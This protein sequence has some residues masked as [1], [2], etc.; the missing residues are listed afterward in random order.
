[1]VLSGVAPKPW[2]AVDAEA[3]LTGNRLDAATID[4]VATASVAGA[5]P[6]P[7]NGYKV[8]L[9]RGLVEETF[10]YLDASARPIELAA[11]NC[12]AFADEQVYK[13][14]SDHLVVTHANL[15]ASRWLAWV[16]VANAVAWLLV[17]LIFQI[18]IVLD[19]LEKLTRSW[20]VFCTGS[21]VLLYLVLAG[22]ALYWTIYSNFIDYWD[23]WIWLI[24]FVLIDMNL[25]GMEGEDSRN[26]HA[27]H[28][29]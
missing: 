25:L 15:T 27:T 24:A 2:R 14:P 6:M 11:D 8:G 28:T 18:E 17:I 23:A 9:V 10:A 1:L 26:V 3:A 20:L 12:G 16:D 7:H 29:K 5:Q 4:R 21:K 22:N 13:A 19:Q